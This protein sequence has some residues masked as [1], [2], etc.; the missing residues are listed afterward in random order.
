MARYRARKVREHSLRPRSAATLP[1][2]QQPVASICRPVASQRSGVRT[3]ISFCASSL[4]QRADGQG[5]HELEERCP[6]SP[7]TVATG[8]KFRRCMP[9]GRL[10]RGVSS[11]DL[12]PLSGCDRGAGF[13]C[14]RQKTRGGTEIGLCSERKCGLS[15][16]LT[17]SCAVA[18]QKKVAC[19]DRFNLAEGSI[20]FP[21]ALTRHMRVRRG[22]A[23]RGASH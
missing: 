6:L 22:A 16:A 13:F 8:G 19:F 2:A 18:A 15:S 20:W 11:L 7:A 3:V 9:V 12:T 10:A 5:L 4:A 23:P 14:I 17:A 21:R 1:A